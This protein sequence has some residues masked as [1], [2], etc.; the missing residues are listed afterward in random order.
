MRVLLLTCALAACT[1][2]AQNN[3]QNE[4]GNGAAPAIT[5]EGVASL[6]ID[7]LASL[8]FRELGTRMTAVT[9][10]SN[11]NS[12]L[13]GLVFAGA[14]HSA[15][16]GLCAAMRAEMEF[17]G[18][19]PPSFSGY[20][21]TAP[22]QVRSVHATQVYKVVGPVEPYAE[23][24]E[25]RAA[26]EDQRCAPAGPVIPASEDDISRAYYFPFE[27]E[28]SPNV[29]LMA[30]QQALT[31]ARE[32]RYRNVS[33]AASARSASEC[34]NPAAL[35]GG[36]DAGN[37]ASLQI[38]LPG[39]SGNRNVIRA[40]FLIPGAPRARLYWSV[41]MEVDI[42]RPPNAAER[43]ERFGRTEIGRSGPSPY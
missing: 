7:R 18:A 19:A 42:A 14:P 2:S 6:P 17:V 24:S 38:T 36:L 43:I 25:Q 4:A 31:D 32:G 34:R 35:L 16:V 11:L 41:V 10:P 8:A 21:P 3:L 23:V 33:C 30:L 28:D 5:R 27:G 40:R 26:E 13:V 20:D 39:L 29:T 1:A 37:L 15:E 12:G 22:M 9:W